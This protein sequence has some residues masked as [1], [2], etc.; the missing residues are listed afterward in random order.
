MEKIKT[1][2]NGTFQTVKEIKR[3]NNIN[4]IKHPYRYWNGTKWVDF[5]NNNSIINSHNLIYA[6]DNRLIEYRNNTFYLSED[7]GKTV[8]KSMPINKHPIK[9]I[10]MFDDGS[11]FF[12][13]NTKGYYSS[14]FNTYAESTILDVNGNPMT[15]I[16]DNFGSYNLSYYTPVVNG[17][18][19][20][21]WGNYTLKDG[22]A[23]ENVHIWYTKDKGRTIREAYHFAP[24]EVRHMHCVSFNPYD[25]TFWAMAG[26]HGNE[27]RLMKGNYNLNTDTWKW[28]VIGT[29]DD[30][31][32]TNMVFWGDDVYYS[33]DVSGGGVIRCKYHELGDLSKRVQIMKTINDTHDLIMSPRGELI[34]L[35]TFY[36][37]TDPTYNFYYSPDRVNFHYI[38]GRYLDGYTY[39][40]TYYSVR[41]PNSDGRVLAGIAGKNINSSLTDIEEWSL[42]PS[43]FLDDFIKEQGFPNAFKPLSNGEDVTP[44][45]VKIS[46][47][48]GTYET[49][50]T[51][52]L[53][54]SKPAT[55]YYTLDGSEPNEK[56]N[57]YNNP[58][59]INNTTVLKFFAKDNN[60]N[61]TSIYS[62]E[63]IIGVPT[64][65]TDGLEI[66]L[67]SKEG[68]NGDIW[69]NLS[70][71][72]NGMHNG[73]INGAIVNDDGMY[74]NGLN[75]RVIVPLPDSLIRNKQTDFT[76]E[77]RTKLTD[78]TKDQEIISHPNSLFLYLYFGTRLYFE[79]GTTVGELEGFT[80]HGLTSN[81]EVYWS[82]SYIYSDG[83]INFYKNGVLQNTTYVGDTSKQYIFKDSSFI[84]GGSDAYGSYPEGIIDN[85]RIYSKSLT[86]SEVRQNY[87]VGRNIGLKN[88]PIIPNIVTNGLVG[89]WNS[90]QGVNG[91]VWENIAPSTK[92]K[93]NGT[94][95]GAILQSSGMSFDGVDDYVD[96]GAIQSID[97]GTDFEVEIYFESPFDSTYDDEVSLFSDASI[98][99]EIKA[100]II[101][102]ANDGST[103]WV[104]VAQGFKVTLPKNT[105]TKINLSVNLSTRLTYIY[106]NDTLLGSYTASYPVNGLQNIAI[107][108]VPVA[109][110]FFFKGKVYSVKLYNRQL[111]DVER[112]QNSLVGKEIGL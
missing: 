59:T 63:Y 65:V 100:S 112:K 44:P 7:G 35:Q 66:Y 64:I 46:T 17:V 28:E 34:V 40:T 101:D 21:V 88:E 82:I 30:Y 78:N 8:S 13:D 14:D 39:E 60:G 12:C 111:T 15:L 43:V 57:V 68:V 19:M 79:A 42:V 97:K 67:N 106:L 10:T 36:G 54:P 11:I 26:D 20:D 108:G 25:E 91:T 27:S 81:E 4:W 51:I 90:K 5:V 86:G 104:G 103:I 74:F 72:N 62:E 83:S 41:R 70:P 69:K 71:N 87:K 49:P 98:T 24:Y 95:Y 33:W 107:G 31:K 48:A 18:E 94:T 73:V 52:T 77:F 55:I 6:R 110:D 76:I 99:T 50:Q 105:V 9:H 89:Y 61:T 16:G 22:N 45:R 102:F 92:G 84:I 109:Q 2:Q 75:N 1:Y 29:G 53:T 3:W 47:I 23:Y 56:S 80:Y 38:N 32:M 96:I 85:I 37:G 58:I 93:Y